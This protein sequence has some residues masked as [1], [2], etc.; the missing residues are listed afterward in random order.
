[1]TV[2]EE[3]AD[4]AIPTRVATGADAPR[5]SPLLLVALL[6]AVFVV[7]ISIAGTAVALPPIARDLGSQPTQLQWVV[8]G[9]NA[10]FALFTLVWGVLSDRI[11]YK[12]TFLAG[13]AVMIAA[14]VLSALAPNL[15]VLDGARILAGIAGAAVFTAATSIISNAYSDAARGR[16]F[17][18]LGTVLGFG[19]ALGPAIAGTLASWVG[20]RGIFVAF[21][22]AVAVSLVFA[23]AIPHIRHA[24][25][26]GRKLVDFRLLGKPHFLAMSLVPVVQAIGFVTMLTYL[27][28]AFSAIWGLSAGQ[29]GLA[30][31]V[32]TVPILV[33]PALAVR[34]I[35]RSRR[36]SVM[37]TVYLALGSMIAGDALLLLVGPQLPFGWIFL[38]MVL[39]GAA[40]GLPLGFIDGEALATVPAHSS[41]TASGVFN[42]LRLGTEAV[43]VGGYAAVL[44]ALIAGELPVG[45][46]AEHVASGQPGHAVEYSAAFR[47]A[48]FG[49]LVLVVA[50]TIA[51]ALLHRATS[52]ADARE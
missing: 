26:A 41:G 32:M 1:M 45:K 6:V 51:I 42:F 10:A 25:V 37:K 19:L 43:A 46:L 8:N 23:F 50:G 36:I 48:Q 22:V 27:P 12:T 11:G 40:M 20:W 44:A 28:V 30:M 31:L 3:S 49:I 34:A 5:R 15:L 2:T 7:P 21:G 18:L 47:D 33:L 29:S 38:P 35:A 4:P 24:H 16:A 17:A 52:R 39:L 13:I 14:S 9:F